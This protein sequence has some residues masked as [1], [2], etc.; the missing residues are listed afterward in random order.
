M[1][2]KDNETDELMSSIEKK[3]VIQMIK[4]EY[5]QKIVKGCYRICNCPYC[6]RLIVPFLIRKDFE[7][8]H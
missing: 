6:K 8:C 7:D 1:E 4:D 3:E 2:K 5:E